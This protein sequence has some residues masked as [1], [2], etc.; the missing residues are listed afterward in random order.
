MVSEVSLCSIVDGREVTWVNEE[1]PNRSALSI[2]NPFSDNEGENRKQLEPN[3]SDCKLERLS[4]SM[5]A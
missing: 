1:D 2:G 4:K 3:V 5:D